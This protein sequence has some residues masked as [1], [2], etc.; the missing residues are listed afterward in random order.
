MGGRGGGRGE[1]QR[2][3]G[4]WNKE[5]RAL[6]FQQLKEHKVVQCTNRFISH[7]WS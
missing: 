6:Q 7:S 5:H 2:K 1:E 3:G 4:G